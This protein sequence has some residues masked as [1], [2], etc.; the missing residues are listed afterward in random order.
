VNEVARFIARGRCLRCRSTQQLTHHHVIPKA[1][2]RIVGPDY[3]NLYASDEVDWDTLPAESR[4]M[5][6]E[7]AKRWMSLP[8]YTQ[9]LCAKCHEQVHR[10]IGIL[11]KRIQEAQRHR[12]DSHC[13]FFKCA[14]WRQFDLGNLFTWFA[15]ESE[16]AHQP[17]LEDVFPP[18][19]TDA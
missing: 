6:Q 5:F 19:R 1:L 11:G 4:L 8:H 15:P 7:S 17:M 18:K 3:W 12:C 13:D 10:E 14:F 2:A 9:R 16:L